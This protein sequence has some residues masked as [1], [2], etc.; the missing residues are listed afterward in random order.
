MPNNKLHNRRYL[1]EI[2]KSLR[3][4]STSAESVLWTI[5]KNKQVAGLKFR[6]QHSI[7][8]YIVDF[9]CPK[10]NLIIELDGEYHASYHAIIRDEKRDKYMESYGLTVLRF[11]NRIV[12]EN[13]E[14][15]INQIL[16]VSKKNTPD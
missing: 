16:E 13:P 15:I 12:F 1:K 10:L 9:Y 6:R 2:R 8:N 7:G 11:E 14:E 3:N 5:L 4:N